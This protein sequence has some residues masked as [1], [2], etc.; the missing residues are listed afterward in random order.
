MLNFSSFK[1]NLDFL[2]FWKNSDALFSLVKDMSSDIEEEGNF[3][4]WP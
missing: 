1:F 4:H 2:F 3:L